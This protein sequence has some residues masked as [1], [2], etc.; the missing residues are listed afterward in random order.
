MNTKCNKWSYNTPNFLKIFQM[1][2]NYFKIFQSE[3]LQ[4]LPKLGFFCLKISHLATLLGGNLRY[5]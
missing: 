5:N 2:K 3:A 4:N 1:A